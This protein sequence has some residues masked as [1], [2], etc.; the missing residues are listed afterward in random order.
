MFKWSSLVNIKFVDSCVIQTKTWSRTL[1]QITVLSPAVF[2]VE[3]SAPRQALIKTGCYG[4][5]AKCGEGV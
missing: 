2:E 3:M 4:A 5:C 1:F